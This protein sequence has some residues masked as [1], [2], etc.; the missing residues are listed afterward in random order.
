MI[1]T[2]PRGVQFIRD[3]EGLELKAYQDDA[4]VWTIGYGHTSDAK[5]PV[6]PGMKITKGTA[7][8]MLKWDIEEAETAI[9]R[10]VKVPL[11]G[12][13]YG[14]LVSFV[15]NL[16]GD[17]LR[18]STLLKKLNRGDYEGASRE[19]GKWSNIRDPITKQLRP[20]RG[21]VR[22]RAEEKALFMTPEELGSKVVRQPPIKG[23][24][25]ETIEGRMA[26][27]QIYGDKPGPDGSTVATLATLGA[28]ISAAVLDTIQ[29]AQ[30]TI[31]SS[32]GVILLVVTVGVAFIGWRLYKRNREASAY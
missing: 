15:F 17:A 6:K 22:R 29:K 12:N 19:F 25:Q 30:E 28:T 23:A 18:K 7:E 32:S 3:H 13:Q 2:S 14:A 4:G 21:L 9:A 31:T 11:N 5:Y 1:N 8:A 27:R 10:L 24:T 26:K 20:A 16:G